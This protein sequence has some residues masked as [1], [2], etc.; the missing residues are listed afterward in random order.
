M[1]AGDSGCICIIPLA[2]DNAAIENITISQNYTQ[3][4]DRMSWNF[5]PSCELRPMPGWLAVG[6]QKSVMKL[7]E[8]ATLQFPFTA[9]VLHFL[10]SALSD[11]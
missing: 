3:V 2:E 11:D 4:T 9:C 8:P 1:S 10:P 5:D 7:F 6:N